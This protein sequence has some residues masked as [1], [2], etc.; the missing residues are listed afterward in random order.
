MSDEGI[1]EGGTVLHGLEPGADQGGEVVE[2]CSLCT[3]QRQPVEPQKGRSRPSERCF[4][5]RRQ[6]EEELVNGRP[7]ER[8]VVLTDLVALEPRHDACNAALQAALE[9]RPQR[10]GVTR[11][12]VLIAGPQQMCLWR[13]VLGDD[14]GTPALGTV[15][16]RRY[17]R[18]TLH[19]WALDSEKFTVLERRERLLQVT[20]GWP[21]LVEK[22]G[23]L[24][25]SGMEEGQAMV[26][27]AEELQSRAGAA[28][29]VDSVGI[30]A[31]EQ[32]ITAFNTVLALVGTDGVSTED[33]VA[34][35]T[36][37]GDVDDPD[38]AVAVL[39]ALGV[40]DIGAE[41]MYRRP[42][43]GPTGAWVSGPGAGRWSTCG[44]QRPGSIRSA[45]GP[46]ARDL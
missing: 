30:A 8:R 4:T 6:F 24:V 36:L 38:I 45:S 35:V 1:E 28:T 10:S 25:A 22:A 14:G 19:V 5:N 23:Q 29:F 21:L 11:S 32:L 37:A 13:M 42:L 17:T 39:Q 40:F 9:P 18:Q 41:G 31:D 43:S 46:W 3:G 44:A 12:A 34:A 16:L 15:V 33:L 2:G 27:L 7:G 26:T 20:G